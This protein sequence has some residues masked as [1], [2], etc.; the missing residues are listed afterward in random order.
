MSV[1]QPRETAPEQCARPG[2]HALERSHAPATHRTALA[3]TPG[4]IVQSFPH[5]PQLCTS[6]AVLVQLPAHIVVHTSGASA[7][8]SPPSVATSGP[9]SDAIA[10]ASD[11]PSVRMTSSSR[12]LG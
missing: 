8:A 9:S 5:A 3:T 6:V 11:A 10:S 2:W 7:R 12:T 4:N 1:S